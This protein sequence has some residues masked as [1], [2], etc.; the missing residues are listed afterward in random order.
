M[1][2]CEGRGTVSGWVM[3]VLATIRWG[4]LGDTYV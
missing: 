1:I 3:V 4:A 2:G